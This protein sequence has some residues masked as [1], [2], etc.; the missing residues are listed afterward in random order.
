MAK[1]LTE[2]VI[3]PHCPICRK[4]APIYQFC[5]DS[6]GSFWGVSFHCDS[7]HWQSYSLESQVADVLAVQAVPPQEEAGA[8]PKK[9]GMDNGYI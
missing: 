3:T 8:E 6:E 2:N 1:I 5:W 9:K 4:P 7:V